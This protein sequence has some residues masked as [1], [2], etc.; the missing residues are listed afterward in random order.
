MKKDIII[1]AAGIGSRLRPITDE[2]PKCMVP[3][4]GKAIIERVLTQ[5]AKSPVE[6]TVWVVSGYKEEVLQDFINQLGVPVNFV[7][8]PDYNRTNNMYS[9]NL[10][11][12]QTDP[13]AGLV[14]INADC[15]Y[16]DA[17]VNEMLFSQG[18]LIAVDTSQFSEES[19]KVTVNG[20]GF[21]TAM[22]KSIPEGEGNHVSMDIYTFN[23][24][25]KQRLLN[26]TNEVIEGGDLNSWTE[27]ALHMLSQQEQNIGVADF[28]GMKWMEIDDHSDLK[29]AEQIFK[30]GA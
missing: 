26:L 6:K 25:F 1:L 17:I 24:E 20:N 16:E 12:K 4:N 29:K 7:P 21:V 10:A 19:M 3:V 28:S 23:Q 15:V 13:E 30:A 18:N 8:N 5:I 27:V 9:L 14:I 11:L 2:L 22:A